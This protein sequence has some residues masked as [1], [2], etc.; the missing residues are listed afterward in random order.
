ME[1]SKVLIFVQAKFELLQLSI[2]TMELR[3]RNLGHAMNGSGWICFQTS[4]E[5]SNQPWHDMTASN[6]RV[7]QITIFTVR[8]P[9]HVEMVSTNNCDCGLKKLHCCATFE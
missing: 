6:K 4:T 5:K 9:C 8:E 2:T 7:N 1:K 3:E